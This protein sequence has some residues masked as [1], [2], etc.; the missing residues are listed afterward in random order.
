M[1]WLIFGLK[2][3]CLEDEAVDFLCQ[4]KLHPS[5]DVFDAVVTM[6][7]SVD[8]CSSSVSV[9]STGDEWSPS[10]N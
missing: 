7:A 1:L 5:S 10:R 8:L 9:F 6:N 2:S 3:C 4:S